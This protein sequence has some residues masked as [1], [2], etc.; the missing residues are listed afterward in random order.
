I[1]LVGNRIH[2]LVLDPLLELRA[3][4]SE[5]GA[6]TLLAERASAGCGCGLARLE[7][8]CI[9]IPFFGRKTGPS[10]FVRSG[11][12][13]KSLAQIRRPR[14]IVAFVRPGIPKAGP[15]KAPLDSL[16]EVALFNEP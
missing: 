10:Q 14:G 9:G 3:R 16:K 15:I 8:R 13:A 11:P 5:R 1:D 2:V 6:E 4:M 12:L 7:V